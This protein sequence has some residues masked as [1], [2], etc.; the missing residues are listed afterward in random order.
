MCST[1][2]NR[3]Q[4]SIIV[5]QLVLRHHTRNLMPCPILLV[6]FFRWHRLYMVYHQRSNL[7]FIFH[8][9]KQC[10]FNQSQG[11]DASEPPGEAAGV[12]TA[13]AAVALPGLRTV[14]SKWFQFQRLILGLFAGQVNIAT[15]LGLWIPDSCRKVK[16]LQ[17]TLRLI[18]YN[19]GCNPWNTQTPPVVLEI[20][21]GDSKSK[22]ASQK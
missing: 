10:R 17:P 7:T 18:T 15:R 1:S 3:S 21:T 13:D 6:W 12:P 11:W 20:G 2:H 9:C 5:S 16:I 14:S 22:T 4:N 19:S 8:N